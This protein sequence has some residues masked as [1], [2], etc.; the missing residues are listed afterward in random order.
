MLRAHFVTAS[1]RGPSFK[2]FSADSYHNE[3]NSVYCDEETKNTNITGVKVEV[4]FHAD[5]KCNEKQLFHG[6][7]FV[8]NDSLC[9]KN[10]SSCGFR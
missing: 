9:L 4:D 10:H 5:E 2:K 3:N 7:R 8:K 6:I 1:F